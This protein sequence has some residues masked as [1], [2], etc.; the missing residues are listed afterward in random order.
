MDDDF[1]SKK[2]TESLHF[3]VLHLSCSKLLSQ[4]RTKENTGK[5]FIGLSPPH[6]FMYLP[7]F[8]VRV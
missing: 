1:D 8:S 5:L 3:E 6:N 4:K 7:R 2:V